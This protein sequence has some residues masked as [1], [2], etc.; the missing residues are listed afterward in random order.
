MP[1][2][3]EDAKPDRF[4]EKVGARLTFRSMIAGTETTATVL[5][6]LTYLLLKHQDKLDRLLKEIRAVQDASELEGDTVKAM[7]YLNACFEEAMRSMWDRA[8][9]FYRLGGL[10]IG[11][12]CSASPGADRRASRPTA[13]RQHHYGPLDTWQGKKPSLSEIQHDY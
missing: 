3:C 10:T 13:G 1:T 7:P 8:L 2:T 5:S 12:S 11:C 9:L 4:P 6:A